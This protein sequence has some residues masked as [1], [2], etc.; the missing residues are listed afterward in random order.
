MAKKAKLVGTLDGGPGTNT[1]DYAGSNPD[2]ILFGTA[3]TG[4]IKFDGTISTAAPLSVRWRPALKMAMSVA[5][6]AIENVISGRGDDTLT[7]PAL[8]AS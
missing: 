7:A 1:L 6:F 4:T 2:A 5:F 3:Y 8:G